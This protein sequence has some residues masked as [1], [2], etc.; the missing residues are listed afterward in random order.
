MLDRLSDMRYR[1][2]TFLNIKESSAISRVFAYCR[3]STFDQ[4]TEN[5]VREIAVFGFK[6]TSQQTIVETVS[7]SVDVVARKYSPP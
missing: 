3:V 5:Q 2:P 1:W 6:I 7:G 4:T